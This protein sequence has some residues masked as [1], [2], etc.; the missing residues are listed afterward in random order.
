M[1]KKNFKAA[2]DDIFGTYKE[3][4]DTATLEKSTPKIYE[5]FLLSIDKAHLVQL[6]AEAE[7]NGQEI[8][9]ALDAILSKHFKS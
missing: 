1:A 6:K 4:S 8:K 7:K 3:P 2:T 5:L 9:D